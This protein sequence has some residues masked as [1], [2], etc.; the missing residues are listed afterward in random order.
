MPF[1]L[2]IAGVLLVVVGIRNT[3]S[4][5]GKLIVGD[6]TGPGNF[7]YWIAALLIIGL[8]GEI[9]ELETPS[10][11][12]LALVLLA[13]VLSN[14]GFFTK[15]VEQLKQGSAQAPPPGPANPNPSS[16]GSN[17]PASSGVSP[18]GLGGVLGP[19][20]QLATGLGSMLG[21]PL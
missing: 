3:A 13:L 6:F 20:G 7:F 21:F 19:V 9:D 4:Q 2:I 16:S 5:L 14:Q 11:M 8:L 15:F 12:M 10:R 1:L 17:L 18:G